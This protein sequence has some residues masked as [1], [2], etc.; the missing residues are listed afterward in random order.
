MRLYL[1]GSLRNPRIPEIAALLRQDGLEVF[2]DWF[3]AGPKADD[4]WR[5]YEQQRGHDLVNA[6]EGPAANHVFDFDKHYLDSC[7][8]AM[9]VLP[10]GRSGHLELGYMAGRGKPTFILMDE[11]PERYDV[12][13]RFA[14]QVFRDEDEMRAYFLLHYRKKL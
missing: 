12:M 13:Y 11:E 9:L 6:L 4:H 3:P 5:D 1:I 7:E 8:T 10:S 2:D 14:R